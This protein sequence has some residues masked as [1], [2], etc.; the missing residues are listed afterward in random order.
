[1]R[2]V[3]AIAVV[4]FAGC[5]DKS[6]NES[7]TASNEGTKAYGQKQYETAIERYQKAT[8]KWKENHVAWYGLA[9]SYIGKKDWRSASDAM[10]KAVAISGDQAMYQMVYG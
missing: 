9:G 6:R 2:I 4:L 5:L 8:E 7:I 3:A 10:E 1:M